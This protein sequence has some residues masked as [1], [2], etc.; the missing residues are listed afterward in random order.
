MKNFKR[1]LAVLLSIALVTHLPVNAQEDSE[2]KVPKFVTVTTFHWNLDLEDATPKAWKAVEKEFFDKVT[3]KNE[4]ILGTDVLVHFFTADNTEVVFVAAYGSWADIEA[5][6]NR[7]GE[8]IKEAWPDEENRKAYFKKRNSYYDGRH[9]DEIYA[10]GSK[11]KL[12]TEKPA[13]PLVMYVQVSKFGSPEGGTQ[14]EYNELSKEYNEEVI[15]KNEF[16]KA[17]Y[18]NFHSWGAD[19]R[20]FLEAYAFTSFADIENSFNKNEELTKAHWPDEAKRK[21]FFKKL[22]RY[23]TGLHSD[24]IYHNVPELNK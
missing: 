10:A 11:A 13:E 21:E 8:L 5:G 18:P 4:Y 14:K 12:M 16:V 17:Y 20:D 22:N 6:Q 15:Q 23:Y 19:R 2:P 9:S 1:T 3:S 24:Y 7:S